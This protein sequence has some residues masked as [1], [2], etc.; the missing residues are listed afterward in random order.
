MKTL[1][2]A[3]LWTALI[4]YL[5]YKTNAVYAYL[6]TPLLSWLNPITKVKNYKKIGMDGFSYSDY[7][8]AYHNNFW[9]KLLSCRYCFGLWLAV[10]VSF[11]LKIPEGIPITYIGG[12][13]V[14]TVFDWIERKMNDE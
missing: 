13:T 3:T 1:A 7:M 8:T 5:L 11:L 6:S 4:L 9:V 2:E 12:Q 14:C 10:G